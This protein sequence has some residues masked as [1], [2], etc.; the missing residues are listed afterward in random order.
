MT[1]SHQHKAALAILILFGVLGIYYSVSAPIFESSDELSHY[2]FV[3]HVADGRGLPVQRPGERT[4]YKQ[5]GSQPPLYYLLAA[6][7]TS[8]IDTDDL[9][10]VLRINPHARL[11]VPLAQDNQN[12]IVHSPQEQFPWRGT[13][14]AVHLIRLFSVALGGGTVLCTY[15]AASRLF[16]GRPAL[17]LGA[18][19]LNALNPMFLFISAS[20]NNDNLVVLLASLT[21]VLTLDGMWY[22]ASARRALLLGVTV[23]LACLTKLSGLALAPLAML[24]LALSRALDLHSKGVLPGFRRALGSPSLDVDAARTARRQA[25]MGWLRDCALITVLTVAIAGWWYLRNLRLYGEPLGLQTM[26]SIVGRREQTPSVAE[27][28]GEFQGFRISYWGLFGAVNVLMRPAWVYYLLDAITLVALGGLL[29]R[30]LRAR[31]RATGHAWVLHGF[32]VLWI[33]VF[34]VSLLRWTLMTLASQGR[35]IFSAM[36]AICALFAWGLTAWFPRAHQWRVLFGMALLLFVLAVSQPLVAILPAYAQPRI[37]G[38]DDV[39]ASAQRI[40][41]TYGEAMRLLAYE[42]SPR[43]VT[44]G[45]EVAITLYW[46][47]LAPMDED[48]SIYLHIFGLQG[49]RLGQRDTYPGQGAYPT[50]RFAPGEVIRDRLLVPIRDD[51]LGPVAAEIEVGLYRLENMHRLQA[52]D[53]RERELGR[54]VIERVKVAVPTTS[55]IPEY[56]LDASF[57]GRVRLVG[58]DLATEAILPGAAAPLTRHWEVTDRLDLDYTVFVHLLDTSD[59]IAGQ[60]DGPPLGDSYPTSFWAPGEVLTDMHPLQ[61]HEDAPPGEYR[62]IVGLY[63][64]ETGERLPVEDAIGNPSGDRVVVAEVELPAPKD[65]S[66]AP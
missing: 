28:L 18:M 2:P 40:N 14:L 7:F 33:A 35:L 16:P 51:A 24:G 61:V 5:E 22:G 19:A 4:M 39:P 11:G 37:L 21:L 38:P 25:V 45:G 64:P 57:A 50:T 63:D 3:K 54:V 43:E 6:S 60:G 13:V 47:A 56:P 42:V 49:Q 65:L 27:L 26:L 17:A 59:T 41:V 58:Y 30:V 9:P 1:S 55:C 52:A 48:Y 34:G 29:W 32:V 23:G 20:V 12:M 66:S 36:S 8:W 53:E 15:Y 44:P 62:I 31:N 46:Q 10:Q